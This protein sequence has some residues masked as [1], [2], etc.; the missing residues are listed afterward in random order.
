MVF[1]GFFGSGKII[2]FNMLGGLIMLDLGM[3][4]FEGFDIVFMN[5]GV[6][7]RFW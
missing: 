5:L 3:I 6:C 4:E 2:L 1:I 7:C